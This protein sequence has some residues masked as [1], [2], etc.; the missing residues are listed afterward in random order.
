MAGDVPIAPIGQ[1]FDNFGR[2]EM[3]PHAPSGAE[4]RGFLAGC[5]ASGAV[6]VSFFQWMTATD[7]EWQAIRTFHF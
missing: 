6:G 5:K 4:V 2:L 7:P 3:G 1:T